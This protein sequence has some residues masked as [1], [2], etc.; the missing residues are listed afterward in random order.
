MSI[1]SR[2]GGIRAVGDRP[3]T[4]VVVGTGIAGLS[5]AWLLDRGGHDVTVYEKET[6]VGGHSNTVDVVTETSSIPV[7]TGFIVYNERNYPNLTALFDN[8]TVPTKASDMSFSASLNGGRLE[9]S[10]ISLNG[11]FG[12]R[13]NNLRPRFWRMLRDLKRFYREAPD[14]LANLSAHLK[15]SIC[16]IPL[17]RCEW[18][19][20]IRRL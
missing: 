6:R 10:D 20:P 16:Q 11:L 18:H 13:R 9:Y 3:Q 5:A 17:P 19:G 15:S 12:Q 14:M 2:G 1:I 4:I 7:D 8:L